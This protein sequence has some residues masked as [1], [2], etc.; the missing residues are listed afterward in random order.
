MTKNIKKLQDILDKYKPKEIIDAL[1]NYEDEQQRKKEW[2]AYHKSMK[3]PVYSKEKVNKII[4]KYT[5]NIGDKK[6][7]LVICHGKVHDKKFEDALLLNRANIVD[8]DIVSDA[9]DEKFMKYLPKDYFD[10]IVMEHCPL[11]NP[12]TIG[13][14]SLWKNL[15]RILKK[16]GKIINSS[17]LW[18]YAYN[19][20]RKEYSSMKKTDKLKIKTEVNE[21]IEQMNFSTVKHIKNPKEKGK[22]ITLITK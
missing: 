12:F 15:Y 17:I 6:K 4:K 22:E 10:V 13:H 2:F 18:L 16:G 11:G 7:T 19:T 14:K 20:T 1:K 21:Y 3:K 9:W 8:P 5:E